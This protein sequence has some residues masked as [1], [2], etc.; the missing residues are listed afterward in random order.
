MHEQSHVAYPLPLSNDSTYIPCKNWERPRGLSQDWT[1]PCSLYITF[2]QYLQLPLFQGCRYPWTYVRLSRGRMQY[3]P[4]SY[5]CSRYL[6]LLHRHRWIFIVQTKSSTAGSRIELISTV[7]WLHKRNLIN[8]FQPID[9]SFLGIYVL[10][11]S[12]IL[13]K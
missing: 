6:L 5:Q 7:N 1:L 4:D 2:D 9:G 11:K 12:K 3:D 13:G 10:F 8:L